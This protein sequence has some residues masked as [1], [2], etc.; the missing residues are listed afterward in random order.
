LNKKKILIF[1]FDGYNWSIDNEEEEEEENEENEENNQNENKIKPSK[2]HLSQCGRHF[3]GSHD[4]I[5]FIPPLPKPLIPLCAIEIGSW[6][7]ENRL[8][9]EFEKF[10][11][12]I[13][14]PCLDIKSWHIHKN[15][16]K[17]KSMPIVNTE[18]RSSVA[19]PQKLFSKYPLLRIDYRKHFSLINMPKKM[20]FMLRNEHSSWCL[21][22]RKDTKFGHAKCNEANIDQHWIVSSFPFLLNQDYLD[23]F[24]NPLSISEPKLFI[25]RQSNFCLISN[26]TWVGHDICE[27]VNFSSKF[28]RIIIISE[29]QF[30]VI[31][32]NENSRNCLFSKID[33]NLGMKNCSSSSTSIDHSMLWK[34]EPLF[35]P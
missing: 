28:W 20:T 5:I 19:H 15:R 11:I 34:L 9:W 17:S 12:S 23:V 14:N 31:L 32:W 21:F 10:G 27:F 4:S 3:I 2:H 8:M 29:G 26:E 30:Q 18:N 22:S 13:R 24:Q 1:D 33:D 6:G 25:G 16:F 35:P 7:I